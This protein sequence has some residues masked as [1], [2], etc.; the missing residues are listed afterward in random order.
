MERHYG[1]TI[2][3]ELKAESFEEALWA[4]VRRLIEDETLASVECLQTG[5]IQHFDMQTGQCVDMGDE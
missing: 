1:V 5:E 2:Q 3:D 4:T